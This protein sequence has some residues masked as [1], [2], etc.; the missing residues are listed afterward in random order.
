VSTPTAQQAAPFIAYL[1]SLAGKEDRAALAALRRGLGR[2]PGTAMEMHRYVT[3]HVPDD[4]EGWRRDAYYL[5]AA[6]FALHPEPWT[7][8]PGGLGSNLGASFASLRMH[9]ESESTEKRFVALLSAHRDDLPEHLRHSVSLLKAHEVRVD[10]AQ[11]LT[12]VQAW[13]AE[14]RWVQRNWAR[15]FW[16]A[17]ADTVSSAENAGPR[18]ATSAQS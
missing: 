4:V 14:N 16:R 3:R 5:I 15:A 10:W 8:P 6:L 9:T 7:D 1:Y 2:A 17:G 12:H 11:L 18:E 13:D